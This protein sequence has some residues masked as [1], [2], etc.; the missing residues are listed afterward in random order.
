MGKSSLIKML[1]PTADVRSSNNAGSCTKEPQ[2]Y[3]CS[4]LRCQVHD[5]PGLTEE[6]Q[7]SWF[8]RLFSRKKAQISSP[9]A[10]KV[11]EY[12]KDVKV[13]GGGVHLLIY[14]MSGER[15]KKTSLHAKNYKRFKDV[16]GN[17]P[18]VVVVTGLDICQ[19]SWENRE[20]WWSKYGGENLG[21]GPIAGHACITAQP[22]DPKIFGTPNYIR[23]NDFYTNSC[24]LVFN[25]VGR[26]VT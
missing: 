14:C 18:V 20:N 24:D 8:A 13:K 7:R 19:I 3:P 15:C 4:D 10:E 12:L 9:E 23:Q 2:G 26:Y 17:V 25:L 11:E 22:P 5:T 21:M 1:C 6:I 16:V